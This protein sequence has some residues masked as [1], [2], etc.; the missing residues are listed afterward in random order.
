MDS[1]SGVASTTSIAHN[2][3]VKGRRGKDGVSRHNSAQSLNGRTHSNNSLKDGLS[4]SRKSSRSPVPPE[5]ADSTTTSPDKLEIVVDAND[6][7]SA[8]DSNNN[9]LS[10]V[11]LYPTK[12]L[13]KWPPPPTRKFHLLFVRNV[14]KNAGLAGWV[15]M[16]SE[17]ATLAIFNF[18]LILRLSYPNPFPYSNSPDAVQACGH[19]S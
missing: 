4:H 7:S 8:K 14:G 2:M 6:N 16:V 3:A 19:P 12:L 17:T 18:H 13:P 5:G 9:A 10:P 15:S 11:P 1:M